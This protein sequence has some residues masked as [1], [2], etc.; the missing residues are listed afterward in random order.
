MHDIMR[1]MRKY[2]C[3]DAIKLLALQEMDD[4]PVWREKQG[5]Y[6]R[7]TGKV[8]EAGKKHIKDL[9]E[10]L[11]YYD[12]RIEDNS[13]DTKNLRKL[14]DD[15]REYERNNPKVN[16]KKELAEEEYYAYMSV[17]FDRW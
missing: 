17:I 16:P 15:L 4:D 3:E 11:K 7:S 9:N 14:K 5:Y 13:L 10:K 1:I 8:T 12:S 2:L 6:N